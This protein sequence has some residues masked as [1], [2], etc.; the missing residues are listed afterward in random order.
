MANSLGIQDAARTKRHFASKQ[1][2]AWVGSVVKM[3]EEG[4]FVTV[5]QEEWDKC[6]H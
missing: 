6:K 3:S 1:P 2:G 4:V 5:S